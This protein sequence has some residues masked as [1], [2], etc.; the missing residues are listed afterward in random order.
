MKRKTTKKKMADKNNVIVGDLRYLFGSST[1]VEVIKYPDSEKP[2][3]IVRK[4]SKTSKY[5]LKDLIRVRRHTL[6]LENK[7]WREDWDGSTIDNT[8]K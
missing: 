1:Q 4:V 7:N 3:C 6:F 5:E 8:Q 2:L